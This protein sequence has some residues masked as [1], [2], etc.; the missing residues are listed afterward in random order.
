[1]PYKY[2][3]PIPA[4]PYGC[5]KRVLFVVLFVGKQPGVERMW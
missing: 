1:M 5:N 3:F 4:S 2:N